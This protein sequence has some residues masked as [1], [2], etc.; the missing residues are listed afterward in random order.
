MITGYEVCF[1]LS[2][3][4]ESVIVEKKRDEFF[5]IVNNREL[6]VQGDTHVKVVHGILYSHMLTLHT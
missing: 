2:G 6:S 1:F 4:N 3:K 5:H